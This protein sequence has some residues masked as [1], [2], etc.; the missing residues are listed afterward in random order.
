MDAG[1]SESGSGRVWDLD[2]DS[3]TVAFSKKV[4][5]GSQSQEAFEGGRCWREYLDLW[6]WGGKH[7][8]GKKYRGAVSEIH[9]LSFSWSSFLFFYILHFLGSFHVCHQSSFVS[10]QKFHRRIAVNETWM[11]MASTLIDQILQCGISIVNIA[12]TLQSFLIVSFS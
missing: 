8:F 3:V 10:V 12:L 11:P 5:S 1:E 9:S 4:Y 6:I 7:R 2:E